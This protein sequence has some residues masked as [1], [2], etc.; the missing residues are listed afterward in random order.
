MCEDGL[1]PGAPVRNRTS[2][3]C[4][5]GRRHHQIGF[6]SKIVAGDHEGHC[7]ATGIVDYLIV[8]DHPRPSP[9]LLPRLMKTWQFRS[10]DRRF[11][12]TAR[13]SF[14]VPRGRRRA[15]MK[16]AAEV[17]F[18]WAAFAGTYEKRVLVNRPFGAR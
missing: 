7:P 3:S 9:G 5:S 1:R 15:E 18:T 17:D 16:K 10:L 11:P 4:S 12:F 2:I 13:R 14:A 6:E 8:K